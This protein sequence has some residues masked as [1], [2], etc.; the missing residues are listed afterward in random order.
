[1]PRAPK[2]SKADFL[3]KWGLPYPSFRY[4]HLRYKNPP[5]KGVFWYFF[6]L[7]VR[8]RDLMLYGTCISC[9]KKVS[10]GDCG[11]F[12]PAS[13][14]GRD[15]LFDPRNCNLECSQ[16]NAWDELHL[17]GY[18]KGLDARYGAGTADELLRRYYEYK[19]GPPIKDWSRKEY[20]DKIT[21]LRAHGTSL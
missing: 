16:C 20:E 4:H 18:A 7:F 2:L 17:I 21:A 6:S 5:E 15:L 10:K 19:A 11:H 3:K 1:M 14:C 8:G 9:G 13:Q 12:I